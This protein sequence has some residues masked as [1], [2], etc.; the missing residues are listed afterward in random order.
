MR[1]VQIMLPIYDNAGAAQPRGLFRDVG[2]ELTERFGGL[3]A[4]RG[5]TI[6]LP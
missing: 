4:V 1:L 3:T 5:M 6:G 2:A